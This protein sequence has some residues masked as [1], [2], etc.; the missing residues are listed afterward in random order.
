VLRPT[1][2]QLLQSTAFRVFVTH[3]GSEVGQLTLEGTG[4]GHGVGLCQWG[5]IGRAR[6]GQ[7]YRRILATYFPGTTVERLY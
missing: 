2:D 1:S 7:P 5:A 3:A 4:A 6:A